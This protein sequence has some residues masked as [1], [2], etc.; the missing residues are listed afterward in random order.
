MWGPA[1]D[2]VQKFFC[3]EIFWV[4]LFIYYMEYWSKIGHILEGI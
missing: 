3:I 1:A 4:D 2:H